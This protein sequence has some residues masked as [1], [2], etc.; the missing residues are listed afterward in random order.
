[1][2]DLVL[3]ASLL[4]VLSTQAI[5]SG[6]G[7]PDSDG[8]GVCDAQDNCPSVSNPEQ[9]S[10]LIALTPIADGVDCCEDIAVT[11]AANPRLVYSRWSQMPSGNWVMHLQSRALAGGVPVDLAEISC[12]TGSICSLS[13]PMFRPTPDG[14][15]VLYFDDIVVSPRQYPLFAVPAGG[16]PAVSLGTATWAT[17]V[18]TPDNQSVIYKSAQGLVMR[19]I[20][21]SPG[22]VLVQDYASQFVVT[23]GWIATPDGRTIVYRWTDRTI[24]ST[25]EELRAVAIAPG[26]TT[27]TLFVPSLAQ[28]G[29]LDFHIDPTSTYVAFSMDLGPPVNRRILF[30]VP[31]TDGAP[32]Q[33]FYGHRFDVVRDAPFTPD[34]SRILLRTPAP[35]ETPNQLWSY[36]SVGGPGTLL[37][38]GAL[39]TEL[40]AHNHRVAGVLEGTGLVSIPI[41]G[42]PITVLDGDP[43]QLVSLGFTT[44]GSRVIY[45]KYP[46]GR[47]PRS[48]HGSRRRWGVEPRRA[49]RPEC[50]RAALGSGAVRSGLVDRRRRHAVLRRLGWQRPAERPGGGWSSHGDRRVPH[51]DD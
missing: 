12:S 48:I 26:G 36:P 17:L 30:T 37:A 41:A 7:C 32:E 31:I 1:M 27:R 10:D 22:S 14:S 28:Y 34:G 2:N 44:D 15:T 47:A 19:P 16:G 25:W 46:G 33:R 49:R 35:T 43:Q 9:E 39:T 3:V 11:E 40:A 42:G 6:A 51:E 13:G 50:R 8:D 18:I 21:G 23:D 29:L 5:A 20:D 45:S 38:E 4:V 24:R